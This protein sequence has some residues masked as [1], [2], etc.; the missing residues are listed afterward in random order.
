MRKLKK[1]YI[2]AIATLMTSPA[3]ASGTGAG[4]FPWEAKLQ[5]L[6]DGLQGTT[7]KLIILIAFVVSG[8]LVMFGGLEGAGKKAVQV[9]LGGSIVLGGASVLANAVGLGSALI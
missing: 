3:F 2:T 6:A 9:I 1:L 4:G 5:M 7:A 8:F